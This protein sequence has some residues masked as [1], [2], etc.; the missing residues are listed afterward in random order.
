MKTRFSIQATGFLGAV[1]AVL[2]LGG[3]AQAAVLFTTQEDFAGWEQAAPQATPD[4]DGSSVNGEGNTSAP[5][6][7]GTA[8]SLGV[9]YS[10]GAWSPFSHPSQTGNTAFINALGTEGT[11]YFDYTRPEAGSGTYFQLGVFMQYDGHWET[12]WGGETDNG[13]GTYTADV[14]YTFVPGDVQTYLQF[15][16]VFN[17]DYDQPAN[18]TVD[19]IR[20]TPIPE[21]TA[22]VLTGGLCFGVFLGRRRK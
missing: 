4:L 13:D 8:G 3:A 1:L 12:F 21:P 19:N 17:S 2:V 9:S 20:V 6:G 14:D 22:L 18:F 16:L 15:G 7:A 5:G 10:G 11:F